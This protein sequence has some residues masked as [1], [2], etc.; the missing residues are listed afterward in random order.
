[1]T[2]GDFQFGFSTGAGVNY[3]IQYSTNL[4]DWIS[5]LSFTSPG[6]WY[7]VQDPNAVTSPWRFYRVLLNQ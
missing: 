7:T 5:F 6:G 2:N 4:T 1:L 3:T